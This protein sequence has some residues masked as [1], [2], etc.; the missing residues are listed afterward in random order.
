MHEIRPF[1]PED[2]DGLYAVSLATGHEGR[3]AS[4]FYRDG[5]LV[6]HLYS[7]PYALLEPG[8]ALVVEDAEGI[9][10]FAVGTSDTVGWFERLEREWWPALREVYPDPGPAA[11]PEWTAD[12][13][14]AFMIHHPV[15]TPRAISASY[16]AHLHLNLAPRLQ[17][18]GVG[19]ALVLRWFEALSKRGSGPI[20]IGTNR[21]NAG[22]IRFW[23]RQG[24]VVIPADPDHAGRTFWMGHQD[25]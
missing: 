12:K 21:A 13:R 14:R 20:H 4:S 18:K 1:K 23:A 2:I 10:G 16:P 22:A 5:R 7:A 9:A 3:D 6:G 24:F 17:G 15:P 8:L 19:A 11:L 25:Q